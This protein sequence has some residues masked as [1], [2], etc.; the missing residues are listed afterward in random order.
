MCEC[1]HLPGSE[2]RQKSLFSLIKYMKLKTRGPRVPTARPLFLLCSQV[3]FLHC[4]QLKPKLKYCF[5][6]NILA[7]LFHFG[8]LMKHKKTWSC[9]HQFCFYSYCSFSQ[10]GEKFQE[11]NFIPSQEVTPIQVPG[12]LS[13]RGGI[14]F[15]KWK[16]LSDDI[17]VFRNS[18]YTSLQ[19]S[20][21]KNV[22]NQRRKV[23]GY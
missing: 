4:V 17:A 3:F 16:G 9:Y 6:Q 7:A 18:R 19:N 2:V 10:F 5:R 22:N 14:R 12:T 1:G 13:W 21:R 8:N 11:L 20:A 15:K 23:F